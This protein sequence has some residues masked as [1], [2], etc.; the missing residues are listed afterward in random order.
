M[1]Q[2]GAVQLPAEGPGFEAPRRRR[3]WGQPHV[4]RAI[5]EASAE[6]AKRFPGTQPLFIGDLSFEKG[7]YMP[8]HKSHRSGLDADISFFLN[9]NPVQ[10]RFRD[11]KP[12]E[13]DAHK[14]WIF[15][16]ALLR[17]GVVHQFY[18]EHNLQE[19]L[20]EEA[21]RLG[22]SESELKRIF[23][24]PRK[25]G[26]GR[27]KLIRHIKGHDDHLHVRFIQSPASKD[28]QD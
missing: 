11:V 23:E 14:T 6:I 3:V 8:P 12:D 4:V 1:R 21:A 17:T 27:T 7:G 19:K 10:G 9:N 5:E 25:I 15:I 13:L 16:E 18:I 22:Y 28:V 2:K 24:F 20:Y 26:T